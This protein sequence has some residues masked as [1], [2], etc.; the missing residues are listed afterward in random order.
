[1]SACHSILSVSVCLSSFLHLRLL[2]SFSLGVSQPTVSL[3]ICMCLSLSGPSVWYM[4]ISRLSAVHFHSLRGRWKVKKSRQNVSLPHDFM[5]LSLTLVPQ[6][7]CAHHLL[8]DLYGAGT[9]TWISFD[10]IFIPKMFFLLPSFSPNTALSS[11]P[12][13][14]LNLCRSHVT[15][16]GVCL[17]IH[18]HLLL[19]LVLNIC[20]IFFRS[21]NLMR[22]LRA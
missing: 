8:S 2:V 13:T 14:N 20:Q 11:V 3:S 21:R 10:R 18:S 6:I 5:T 9:R 1:M 4:I 7:P 22:F 19:Y 15:V 16:S 17:Q 12:C